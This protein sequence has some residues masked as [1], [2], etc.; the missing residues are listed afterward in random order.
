MR[1]LWLGALALVLL[2]LAGGVALPVEGQTFPPAHGFV[3]DFA[4]LLSAEGKAKLEAQLAKLENDTT[5]EVAV[6]TVKS[7]E[8]L[9]IEDYAVRLFEAWGIGKKGKDNGVLFI[10]AK[11]ERKVRIEVGYGLEPV[12]TDGRAGRILDN[13]VLP[14]FKNGDYEGGIVAGV[15]A[16][17][18]YV[19][20]GSPPQP[21]EDNP[22]NSVFG[23]YTVILI[24]LGIVTIYLMGYMA[25]T[26]SI[27]LGGI[28]GVVVGIVLGLAWGGLLALILVPIVSGGVGAGLDYILTKNHRE[29]KSGG[30]PTDW[31]RT[32]GGFRGPGGGGGFGGGGFGGFGGGSSGGGGASRGW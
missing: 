27:W 15:A 14:R 12:I 6:V 30:H 21:L 29:R 26:K 16:I 8:G 28:W 4:A 18:G 31:P 2:S 1:R 24:G 13:E 3:N 22:V 10:V 23:G 5:A 17:E 9:A 32:W 20:G 19:R 11:E 7:L 25:R